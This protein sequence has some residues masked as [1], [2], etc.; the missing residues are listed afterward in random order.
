MCDK[1]DRA[2][3][4]VFCRDLHLTLTF[5]G[6]L[7]KDLFKGKWSLGKSCFKQNYCH[8]CHTRFIVFFPQLSCCIRSLILKLN[9][10]YF[11]FV[12]ILTQQMAK[13]QDTLNEANQVCAFIPMRSPFY[14]MYFS[15]LT[16]YYLLFDNYSIDS[17][18]PEKFRYLDPWWAQFC[19]IICITS[20]SSSQ[21]KFRH[22]FQL[23]HLLNDIFSGHAFRSLTLIF[24]YLIA[25]HG[26]Q[27]RGGRKNQR[28]WRNHG[29]P[30]EPGERTTRILSWI[31]LV[32]ISKSKWEWK[33]FVDILTS[34]FL[35]VSLYLGHFVCR[36]NRAD[37]RKSQVLVR[38]Y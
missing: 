9:L 2:I 1:R 26:I 10:K 11:F 5:S 21:L 18:F 19:F 20:V 30:A 12:Q 22:R 32:F 23:T 28:T 37:C 15:L 7:Q 25:I 36:R 29:R 6:L 3:T 8:A 17:P 31:V 16:E 14:Y 38:P 4:C 13:L 27:G 33:A 24:F 34:Y 35:F